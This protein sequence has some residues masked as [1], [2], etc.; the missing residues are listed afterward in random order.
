M[1]QLARAEPVTH[2]FGNFNRIEL[3]YRLKSRPRAT[4]TNI[5]DLRRKVR[6]WVFDSNWGKVDAQVFLKTRG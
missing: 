5:K 2:S 3:R 6:G 4:N 1:L